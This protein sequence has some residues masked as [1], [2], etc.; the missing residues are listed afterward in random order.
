MKKAITRPKY[1]AWTEKRNQGKRK[2]RRGGSFVEKNKSVEKKNCSKRWGKARGKPFPCSRGGGGKKK[3][4]LS[5][6]ILG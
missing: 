6:A 3:L 2:R 1:V 4:N 5:I